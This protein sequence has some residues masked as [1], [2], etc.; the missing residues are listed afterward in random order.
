MLGRT[1]R[2]VTED[3][4]EAK[5][6][7]DEARAK[8]QEVRPTVLPPPC[9]ASVMPCCVWWVALAAAQPPAAGGEGLRRGIAQAV[10]S[11][12]ADERWYG[13]SGSLNAA[14]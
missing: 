10:R 8:L 2:K 4:N 1:A 3:S 6:K 12:G 11:H 9:C 7:H 13:Y 14:T 5:K